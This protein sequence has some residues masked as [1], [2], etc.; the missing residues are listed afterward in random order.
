MAKKKRWTEKDIRSIKKKETKSKR[1]Y[2]KKKKPPLKNPTE[3]IGPNAVGVYAG[4]RP[5]I[6]DCQAKTPEG[7][8]YLRSRWEAN[9]ARYLMWLM[10]RG[11]IQRWEYEPDT[12]WFEKIKR[13]VR[14]YLPDFKIWE[15]LNDE[16]YY[17]EV[18]GRMDPKSATKLKRMALY[19]PAIRLSVVSRPEYIEIRNKLSTLIPNWET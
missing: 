16:P 5:D 18:K 14:S 15:T 1:D 3:K 6:Q 11:D 19:H 8:L 7:G 2:I 9:Y 10:S 12:F 13:G 17:V 4:R